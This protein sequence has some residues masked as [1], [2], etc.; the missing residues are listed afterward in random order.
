MV[1][2]FSGFSG[3][4]TNVLSNLSQTFQTASL[5]AGGYRHTEGVTNRIRPDNWKLNLPYSF[6]I[7]GTSSAVFG[8]NSPISGVF[9]LV[10]R[11][12]G[13]LFNE[14]ILPIN[15]QNI[16]QDEVFAITTTP[17]QGGVVS[18]HNGVVFKDVVITG[19]TGMRPDTKKSG[20]HYFQELRNYFR[21]YAEIKK[22]P[23]QKYTRLIFKN[24]KDNEQ[25]IVE[26]V[27]F[28]MKR[29]SGSSFLYNYNIVLKVLGARGPIR[30][31]NIFSVIDPEL[32]EIF[33]SVDAIVDSA[34]DLVLTGRRVFENSG[35]FISS[36]KRDFVDG[37]L[38]P[39]ELMAG[40]FK[41]QKGSPLT[42]ADIPRT[43]K[44]D[45]SNRTKIKILDSSIQQQREGNLNFVEIDFPLDTKKFV[46]GN[47]ET[48]LDIIPFVAQE[49]LSIN[50]LTSDEVTKLLN[51]DLPKFED[52]PRKFYTDLK[53]TNRETYAIALEKFG[54]GD[55]DYNT[56]IGRESIV[57]ANED[58]T[59]DSE[60]V[61]IL[62][63]FNDID[64]AMN[65]M[66]TTDLPFRDTFDDDVEDIQNNYD[67]SLN[68][69]TPRS[70]DEII[71]P[72][73]ITLE[74]LASEYLGH[75]SRWIEIAITNNLIFPYIEEGTTNPRVKK[76]G[77]KIL[78]P[79]SIIEEAS[80]VPITKTYPI[81]EGLNETERNLG[82]DI[83]LDKNFNF[84][85]NNAHD[86]EL[87]S[88]AGNGAQ[89][90]IIKI[91]LEKGSLKQHPQIGVG[92]N[93]GEKI[94]H[95][96]DIRDDMF[97]SILSDDRFTNINDLTFLT[98]GSTVNVRF[99][100]YVKNLSI[101]VPV[102]FII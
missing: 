34:T 21:A 76:S 31:G 6:Q 53:E 13:G 67:D 54:V 12:I 40:S 65:M 55:E 11:S 90:V 44:R 1:L 56:F 3:G 8:A 101:P 83:K 19:T 15:P 25:L 33:T 42:I 61:K 22:D 20:Y 29:D 74:D 84:I 41:V 77:D 28:T 23:T 98:E 99:N 32:G 88:G 9:R 97:T 46:E 96:E 10:E 92:L 35:T 57:T 16:T 100:L 27:K 17:T 93:I 36:F 14:F 81:T 70:A 73:N 102:S 68:I 86:V 62:E 66:L 24:R 48:A 39:I 4:F 37:L 60:E 5:L 87:L 38:E 78:I 50:D 64:R 85:L 52:I 2:G 95:G 94:R 45:L 7:E 58:R 18:E 82:V 26:P 71:L 80:N 72:P 47:P 63:A 51:E 30:L 91:A 43:P 89:A 75:P 79:K 49:D 59:P 69:S